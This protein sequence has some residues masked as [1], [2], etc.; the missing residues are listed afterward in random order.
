MMLLL[1]QIYSL[2]NCL[3]I[4]YWIIGIGFAL[5]ANSSI[6]AA[7]ENSVSH[8]FKPLTLKQAQ[9]IALMG[10]P[11]I[12]SS[13]F[14]IK[15]GQE[16]I[17][18]T[19]ARYFP[20]IYGDAAGVAP[21]KKTNARIGAGTVEGITNPLIL[22]H[23]S[24][25]VVVNQLI[26]DFGQTSNL[27]SAAKSGVEAKIA[28]SLSVRDRVIFTVTRAYYNQ[29]L[30]QEI[31]TV[32][33][34]THE[35]RNTLLEKIQLLYQAK[36]KALFDVDITRQSVDEAN[37]LVLNAQN[38]LDDAQ[39]ELSQAMGYG[40]LQHFS[41]T[42]KISTHPY[43][44][45]LEPLLKIAKQSNP[46][47]ITLRAEVLEK[48]FQYESAQAENYPTVS[49]AGYAGMNPVREKSQMNSS[50][51][52]AGVTVDVPI[53]TGGLITAKERKKLFE[54]KAV[55]KELISKE[56]KLMR[57]VRVAWNNVQSSYQNISVLKEL[58]LNN[59][60]GLELAQASY[61]FG[62]IS[63]VDLVQEHLRKT[64]SEVSFTKARYEYLINRSLLNLLLGDGEKMCLDNPS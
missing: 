50:Y 26:T 52:T 57:D 25:G 6:Y 15:A 31:L 62:L 41:L 12:L 20:Q 13:K 32:A 1:K 47:L 48:K 40:E 63:I 4:V 19:E 3:R 23:V 2:K 39:A 11:D 43:T 51:A 38:D 28:K 10:H 61:E 35:V 33:Q 22:K 37:L 24:Y 9:E 60:K 55:E 46:D 45:K 5:A 21:N 34:E 56:N 14:Q 18:Q 42:E 64:Q 59:V 49:A 7:H 58:F 53:F 29:L 30:A 54:M 27:V 8:N 44:S 36:L 17:L 16:E